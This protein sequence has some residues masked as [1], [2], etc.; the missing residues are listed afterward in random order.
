MAKFLL[1]CLSI[2]TVASAMAVN[3]PPVPLKS[4]ENVVK[5]KSL[6]LQKGDRVVDRKELSKG[7]HQLTV[8]NA[9]GVISKRLS[10]APSTQKIN[11]FVKNQAIRKVSSGC[12]LSED[13]EGWDGVDFDWLPDGF[14]YKHDSGR[15][16]AEVWGITPDYAFQGM[17]GGL[18][19]NCISINYDMGYVDEWLIFPE[20]T[21]GENMMLTLDVFNDGIWY[22][23]MEN[24]DWESFEYI[25]DKII[26]Y[27]Q[28]VMISE[29]GGKNWKVLK[30]LAEDFMDKDLEQLY[31][32]TTN[33]LSQ[34]SVS[35][36]DYAGKTVKLA[37]R[38]FGTD[39]NLGVID[40][41]FIGNLPLEVSYNNPFGTLFFGMSKE[42]SSLNTSILVGP[43]YRDMVFENTTYEDD[44]TYVWNYFG[45]ESSWEQSD[46]V[47][48][49]VAYH[50]DYSSE[51]ATYN[52]LYYMPTL[53]GSAPGYSEGSFTRGQYLQAGGKG[54]YLAQTSTGDNRLIDFG[55]SVI[56]PATEGSATFT[57]QLVPI[58]GYSGDSDSY[59]TRYTFDEEGDENNYVKMT[60]YMD[61][62]FNSENPVVIRGVH[63]SAFARLSEG[64]RMMAEIIPLSDEGILLD[65]LA[66]AYCGYADMTVLPTN[67]TNDFVS[68]NFTFD[69]PIIM[70]SDVCSAYIV[71]ISGFNDPENVEYF[72]PIMSSNPNPD[73]YALGWIQKTIVM[74]GNARESMTPVINYTGSLIAF[75]IMLDAEFPWL[76]GPESVE[77]ERNGI[78]TV[79]FDSSVDGADLSFEN[80][81]DWLEAKAEGIYDKTTVTFQ[82]PL[83]DQIKGSA[84][85]TVKGT[86]VSHVITVKAD[87]GS[88]VNVIGTDSSDYEIFNM[89][90]LKVSN[91]DAPGIY[92]IKDG[93][94]NVRKVVVD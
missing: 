4:M 75:Y 41:I 6:S 64:A 15:E 48:L 79:A 19:G 67:G 11:P 58:F 28:Q 5:Q 17:L 90:G 85:V 8:R 76:E 21:L 30:S 77:L 88:A 63:A 87:E 33:A 26:A 51:F 13:F 68:L 93:K 72:N 1:S 61:Y 36:A 50:T 27:D 82:A 92:I 43:V 44:A 2:A 53:T 89:S 39:G 3:T 31:D 38:Y 10:V 18:T 7:V 59:W 47:D 20:V 69:A 57:D 46:D 56:D 70:S 12:I 25:G 52:N 40:N 45:P 83:T 34:V 16:D 60:S 62:F 78:A 22:F 80:L 73:E 14:E 23:S 55:L 65:P 84:E 94:G 24:I 37:F 29:D 9:K 54:Q 42:S 66:T 86:G 49:E 74:D 81:P 32:E 35:L 91:S 71:R